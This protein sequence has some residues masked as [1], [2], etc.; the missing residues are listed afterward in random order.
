[1]DGLVVKDSPDK[2][3]RGVISVFPVDTGCPRGSLQIQ[4][5]FSSPIPSPG[6]VHTRFWLSKDWKLRAEDVLVDVV[7]SGFKL[8]GA[9][10]NDN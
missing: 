5:A 9:I 3:A 4:S 1:M 7:D 10:S 2:K 6:P 8:I